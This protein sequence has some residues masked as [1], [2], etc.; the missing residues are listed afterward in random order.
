[1]NNNFI[2][3]VLWSLKELNL[4]LNDYHGEIDLNEPWFGNEYGLQ[5]SLLNPLKMPHILS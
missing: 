5:L 1:M 4:S 3:C 2:F